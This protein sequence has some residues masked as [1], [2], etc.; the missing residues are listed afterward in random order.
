VSFLTIGYWVWVIACVCALVQT[1]LLGLHAWEHR[2][3]AR[4]RRRDERSRDSSLRVALLSP[5]KGMDLELEQNLQHLLVQDYSN[6]EV[7]FIVEQEDDPAF[8]IIQRLAERSPVPVRIIVAGLAHEIGQKIHN[9]IVAT[10]HISSDV[11]ILAFVDSDV[12]PASDWL[13]RLVA[14]LY[15]P[16]PGA[17]TGYRWYVPASASLANCLLC[18][19]NAS[20]AS[21]LGAG[22]QHIVWG[23]SWAMRRE[24]FESID[25]TSSWQKTLSDDL[26]ASQALHAADLKIHYEPACMTASPIDYSMGGMLNFLRRQHL[27]GRIYAPQLWYRSLAVLL[28]SALAASWA[29]CI[30]TWKIFVEGEFPAWTVAF[31]L[32]WY[33]LQ[34]YRGLVRRDLARIYVPN[35]SP[36]M[37]QATWFDVFFSPVSLFVNT[38]VMVSACW[39]SQ[40]VWRGITYELD[41]RG[42]ILQVGRSTPQSTAISAANDER[43]LRIDPSQTLEEIRG[44]KSGQTRDSEVERNRSRGKLEM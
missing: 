2:R 28:V 22:S 3:F 24:E 13:G 12:C 25:I 17:V 43:K 39:G 33:G 35:W 29:A 42:Q 9:L 40:I 16:V 30:A 36:V 41:R 10:E 7:L 31:L 6:Y 1:L 18:S 38:A 8:P 23:G 20:V 32:A 11:K 14:R 15:R 27:I 19:I 37:S 21:L 26:V 44:S 34:I 5:C 4:R